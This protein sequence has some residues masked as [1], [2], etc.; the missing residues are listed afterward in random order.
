MYAWRF[1][2]FWQRIADKFMLSKPG[3][4]HIFECEYMWCGIVA[5]RDYNAAKNIAMRGI[6]EPN[7]QWMRKRVG[8]LKHGFNTSS[9]AKSDTAKN[10]TLMQAIYT[11]ADWVSP[12]GM[13]EADFARLLMSKQ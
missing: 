13:S 1:C 8:I 9:E 11:A 10:K 12:G 2:A 4:S 7:K 6:L 3:R 5:P